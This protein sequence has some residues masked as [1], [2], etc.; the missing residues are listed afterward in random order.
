MKKVL[1]INLVSTLLLTGVASPIMASENNT[2][3]SNQKSNEQIAREVLKSQGYN[4]NNV[5]EDEGKAK[6]TVKGA[7]EI[8]KRNKTRINNAI[9]GAID[10]IPMS[11]EAKAK[12]KKAI[13]VDVI[14]GYLTAYTDWGDRVEDAIYNAILKTGAPSWVAKPIAVTLAFLIPVL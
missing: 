8:L 4:L 13:T 5:G 14:L 11:K 6:V 9:K 7:I 10:K 12:W 3:V 1:T 2:T